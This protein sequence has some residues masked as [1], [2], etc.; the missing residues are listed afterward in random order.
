MADLVSEFYEDFH[1]ERNK[2][3]TVNLPERLAFI[4]REVGTGRRVIELGCRYGDLLST[5]QAGNDVFG[6]DIDRNAARICE[7]RF[8]VPV[9][10]ADLS[11]EL[12]YEADSFDVVVISEVLEHL[13]YPRV[14]LGEIARIL[15]PEG[16]VVGS[17]P[18]G[19][20]LQN[21]IRFL[22]TGIVDRDRTHLHH[23]SPASLRALLEMYF[24]EVH[25]V[26]PVG[27][28]YA[29]LSAPLLANMLLFSA[30]GPRPR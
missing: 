7:E 28:R 21:R 1:A 20:R 19:T 8:G 25:D 2:E 4:K 12:P 18:N 26:E 22:R 13:P 24:E 9:Q 11:A 15:R 17:V 5:F 16:K 23:F 3:G 30:E 10:I 6:V 14:T 27:G 29:R